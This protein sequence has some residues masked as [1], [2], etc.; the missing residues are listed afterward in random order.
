MQ[1]YA[2]ADFSF[3]TMTQGKKCY[4]RIDKNFQK[5]NHCEEV[6]PNIELLYGTTIEK[7]KDFFVQ[8]ESYEPADLNKPLDRATLHRDSYKVI[9]TNKGATTTLTVSKLWR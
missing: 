9:K 4:W 8:I 2:E 3:V 5:R 1:A 7:R 6:R